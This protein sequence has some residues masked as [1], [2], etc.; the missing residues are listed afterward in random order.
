M[1]PGQLVRCELQ[2]DT[3]LLAGL[4]QQ[5][6]DA[7]AEL[8][9]SCDDLNR[10]ELVVEEAVI[11]IML[12]AYPDGGGSLAVELWQGDGQLLHLQLED[13]GPPFN[14]LEPRKLDLSA[15]LEERSIGGLGVHLVQSLSDGMSYQREN[16]SNR[17]ELVFR[18][19]VTAQEES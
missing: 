19:R 6:V 1:R 4:K 18:Q 15:P 3:R 16:G 2:A 5:L 10:F 7:V 12:Y 17:L 9:W 8:G 14:P 13:Q 11:N